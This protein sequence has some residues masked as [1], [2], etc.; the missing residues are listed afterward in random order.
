MSKHNQEAK[1]GF[2][3]SPSH[4]E[5]EKADIMKGLK[6]EIKSLEKITEKVN[7]IFKDYERTVMDINASIG[8]PVY[9]S[10]EIKKEL[11][12]NNAAA[13]ITLKAYVGLQDVTSALEA[14]LDLS[15]GFLSFEERCIA[16]MATAE[17][18]ERIG[19]SLAELS[20]QPSEF[21][22]DADD[23]DNPIDN[24]SLS[25]TPIIDNIRRLAEQGQ[26][27]CRE[28]VKPFTG[29]SFSL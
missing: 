10:S 4:K 6:R 5:A 16:A 18:A 23:D 2:F 7:Q 29:Q 12:I 22:D 26:S 15:K 3:P 24:L 13:T 28:P 27:L 21:L 8:H 11:T 17:T 14:I 25:L 1:V 9:A 19:G 20:L